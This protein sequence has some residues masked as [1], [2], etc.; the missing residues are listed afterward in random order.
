MAKCVGG[1]YND[2]GYYNDER[3]RATVGAPDFLFGS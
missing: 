1:Y 2:C 3:E